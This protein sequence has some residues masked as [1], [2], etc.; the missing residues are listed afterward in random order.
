[1]SGLATLKICYPGL[2]AKY[3]LVSG[4]NSTTSIAK[5]TLL[6]AAQTSEQLEFSL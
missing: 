1:M 5:A 2:M 6:N 3:R 4:E